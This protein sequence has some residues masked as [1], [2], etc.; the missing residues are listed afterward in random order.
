MARGVSWVIL[1]D[2][3]PGS[4]RPLHAQRQRGYQ[5]VASHY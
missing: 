4:E 3:W 1:V 2:E 5:S